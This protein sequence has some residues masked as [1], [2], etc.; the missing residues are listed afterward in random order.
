MDLSGIVKLWKTMVINNFPHT[1]GKRMWTTAE[2]CGKRAFIQRKHG[3]TLWIT[4]GKTVED[5]LEN[6]G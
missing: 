6:R 1:G 5:L 3:K 4:M 2:K